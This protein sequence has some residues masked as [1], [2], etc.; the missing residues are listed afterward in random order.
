MYVVEPTGAVEDDP[1][2]TDKKFRGN[3]TKSFAHASRCASRVRSRTGK[4]TRPERSRI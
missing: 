3:P 4:A 2:L 1:K